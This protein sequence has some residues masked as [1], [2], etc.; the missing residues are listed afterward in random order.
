MAHQTH[1][2]KKATT[3]KQTALEKLVGKVSAAKQQEEQETSAPEERHLMIAKAAYLLAEQRGFQ[4]DMALNDWLQAEA[5][6]D[7]RFAEKH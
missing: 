5:G 1:H 3:I 7:A 4:G 2:S 6:V